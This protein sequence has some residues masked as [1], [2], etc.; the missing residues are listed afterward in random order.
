MPVG[1]THRLRVWLRSLVPLTN[2]PAISQ[3][4][5]FNDS[6][7]YQ[8]IFKLEEFKVGGRLEFNALGNKLVMGFSPRGGPETITMARSPIKNPDKEKEKDRGKGR[9]KDKTIVTS[10]SQGGHTYTSHIP[11]YGN[12]PPGAQ[13]PSHLI[14]PQNAYPHQQLPNGY[15]NP[16]PNP[17]SPADGR[18]RVRLPPQVQK[19]KTKIEIV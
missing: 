18:E 15:A 14:S 5:P 7:I 19:S 13:H 12:L 16:H 6:Y 3:S 4:L 2:D 17:A 1:A 11:N 8:R 10:S 9:E